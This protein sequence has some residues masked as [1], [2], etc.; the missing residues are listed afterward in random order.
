MSPKR[1]SKKP[2]CTVDLGKPD[3]E[4]LVPPGYVQVHCI[5]CRA[6]WPFLEHMGR[7]PRCRCGSRLRR[8]IQLNRLSLGAFKQALHDNDLE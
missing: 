4:L 2:A 8:V 7:R 3:S 5:N 1:K 6:L